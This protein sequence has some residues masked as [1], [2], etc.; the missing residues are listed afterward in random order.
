MSKQRID[1]E[2]SCVI[3]E[4][5]IGSYLV[6]VENFEETVKLAIKT[7]IIRVKNGSTREYDFTE[8]VGDQLMR[9]VF[10]SDKIDKL[11]DD[12]KAPHRIA[13]RRAGF[14]KDHIRDGKLGELIL[15]LIMEG[16]YRFPLACHKLNTKQSHS[17]EV[18]GADGLFF[19]E[20]KG[21]DYLAIGE[22]KIYSDCMRGLRE[23]LDSI[24]RFHGPGAVNA[25]DQDMKIVRN[26]PSGNLDPPLLD[27]L[28][29]N[30]NDFSSLRRLYPIFVCYEEDNF[31]NIL[32]EE[33]DDGQ[34]IEA[35]EEI[36]TKNDHSSRVN[37]AF[38]S[39]RERVKQDQLHFIFL[40]VKNADDFRER[41]K[42]AVF[43]RFEDIT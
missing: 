11:Y 43:P 26:N 10:S 39:E 6:E 7:Y 34:I 21:D 36:V 18:L 23:A 22:S 12:K 20:W 14:K 17:Q 5:D 2:Q 19:G 24:L 30:L 42:R 35:M 27:H 37:R 33:T 15:F 41:L 8:F 3:D 31:Q 1:F 29:S 40:P 4:S 25:L 9:Y 16:F 38:N 13:Q 28:L 32:Q